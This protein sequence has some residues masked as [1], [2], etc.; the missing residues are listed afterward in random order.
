[1]KINSFSQGGLSHRS[2]LSS[3][4]SLFIQLADLGLGHLFSGSN[5]DLWVLV[6]NIINIYDRLCSFAMNLFQV[7]WN[8]L[9]SFKRF[10]R[11]YNGSLSTSISNFSLCFES[12]SILIFSFNDTI[13]TLIF[14][15]EAIA[16]PPLS[17]KKIFSVFFW[18][19]NV[20]IFIDSILFMM[21]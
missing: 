16:Y 18:N 8:L 7:F 12:V 5:K 19:L 4:A 17:F 10:Q 13:D 15:N 3:S 11:F 21:S 14:S 6:L 20:M 1:M 2:F 9:E